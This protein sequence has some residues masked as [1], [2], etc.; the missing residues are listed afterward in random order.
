MLIRP[1]Q[2]ARGCM[3]V[4]MVVAVG[5]ANGDA[6]Q[7]T[8]MA[9]DY[10]LTEAGQVSLAMYDVNGHMVRPILYGRPQAPGQYTV[11]WDGLDRYGDPLPAGNYEW[12]LLR[13]P[14]FT[15]EFLVNVGINTPWSPFDVWPGNHFGPNVVLVDDEEALYVG[16]VSSEGPPCLLKMA[17]D[18]SKKHWDTAG[19][20]L[21][22]GLVGLARIGKAL[23]L[24]VGTLLQVRRADDGKPLSAVRKRGEAPADRKPLLADLFHARDDRALKKLA[25]M[26]LAAGKDLLALT[27]QN[28]DELRLVWLADDAVRHEKTVTVPKPGAVAVTP[29]GQVY[30]VSGNDLVRVD[31]ESGQ[32]VTVV[33][34]LHKPGKLAYDPVFKD[35][36]VVS[37]GNCIRRY[38]LPD[39]ELV[40]IYGRPEG[41]TYGLFNPLDFGD[42]LD[43][44]ADN[45][46]GFVTAEQY[47]R[48]V[49]HFTG[50]EKHQVVNQWF[51]GLQWGSQATIDP[52]DPTIVYLPIDP[53][54]LGRGKIDFKTRT[55]TLTHLY[56]RIDHGSWSVGGR[57]ERDILPFAGEE[58]FYEVR[59]VGEQTFL[60]NRGAGRASGSVT[61]LRV[62]E[63]DNRLLPV[64]HLGS[65]HPSLDTQNPPDWWVAAL[66]RIGIRNPKSTEAAKHLAYSWSD[67][68]H[69]G[70]VDIEEISLGSAGFHSGSG[71]CYV[72]PN[73]DIV[74]PVRMDGVAWTLTPNEG[75]AKLPVWNW[76][77][78]RR[79][80][81]WYPK[82]EFAVVRPGAPTSA[83]SD[84]QGAIYLTVNNSPRA[85]DQADAPPL[86]WPNNSYHSS[87]FLKWNAHNDQIFSVGVHTDSKSGEAGI[88]S[89]VRAILGEV[90]DCLVVMDAC[91][92][93][94]VWT[95]D[96]LYAGAFNDDL[97]LPAKLEPWERLAYRKIAHDDNQWGQVV[98]T[99]TGDVLWGPMRDNSTPFYR[100]SGWD[101]WDRQRGRFTLKTSARGARQ[102]GT[103]LT[104]QYF[105]TPAL[106]GNA[107]LR[108]VDPEIAFGPMRGDHRQVDGPTGWFNSPDS[109]S[110]SQDAPV[111]ARW[112][113]FV[114]APLSEGFTF[115]LYTYGNPRIGSAGSRV[116]MWLDQKLVIDCWDQVVLGLPKI[117]FRFTRGLVSPPIALQSGQ[118]VPIR[119]ECAT[120]PG[121]NA[122]L[123]LYWMSRSFDLR[124][125]PTAYL[126]PDS[127]GLETTEARE[128]PGGR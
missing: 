34:A 40:A 50:R 113:G 81:G 112:T 20:G 82:H 73:W 90:K 5:V 49:A 114:E 79:G 71:S 18:G 75:T 85:T 8:G 127:A 53:K 122:H 120:L 126:Y 33:R 96:G 104:A 16:S 9:I 103:G 36:L 70:L 125:I 109:D 60:V 68:N 55:W 45:K 19:M 123:H 3:W 76:N 98:E 67:H 46:G 43:I 52:A 101:H 65:L 77:H 115:Q 61:V 51:G 7:E 107:V 12:R 83:Y 124:H 105:A 84:H 110:L 78:S 93:A 6:A 59:H 11:S 42:I 2:T 17:L 69:N 56:D 28:S 13:T 66:R 119:I 31:S 72:G 21:G 97:G 128:T 99:K 94:S 63:K 30:V 64:A 91:S 27:N 116:R 25:P 62:D 41:R 102:K 95:R 111:S 48:R 87:R 22:N 32:I 108:K 89:D 106:T 15:R 38:H 74:S 58:I 54:H 44:A 100:I 24:Q 39:G 47:P 35:L 88:F 37:N 14:G 80:Q 118:R 26:S 23:Y 4:V 57:T 117:G 29:G 121:R 86:T 1:K 10:A 92:P